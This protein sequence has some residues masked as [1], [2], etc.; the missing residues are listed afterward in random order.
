MAKKY[1]LEPL[2]DRNGDKNYMV[3][4]LADNRICGAVRLNRHGD[5]HGTQIRKGKLC[6]F[7]S[8]TESGAAAWCLRG[9]P[10][11]NPSPC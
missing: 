2:A 6:G 5:W 9:A 3:V 1:R 7:Y 4:R 11:A 8:G 10:P